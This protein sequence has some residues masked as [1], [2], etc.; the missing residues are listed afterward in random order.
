M[1]KLFLP[2]FFPSWR[3]FSSIGPSPRIQY[4]FL[5]DIGEVPEVW[6]SFLAQKPRVT[7]FQGIGRLFHN[8][9]WNESLYMNTCAEHFFE[10]H[11]EFREQE[12]MRRLLRRISQGSIQAPESAE[13]LVFRINAVIRE[14]HILTEEH[15]FTSRPARLLSGLI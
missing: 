3:F 11:S 7:F 6:Q 12:I 14:N 15:I 5:A 4:A 1:L 13:Y 8:P 2:I 9:G 10:I